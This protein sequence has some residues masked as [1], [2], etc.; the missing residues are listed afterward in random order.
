[1]KN[2]K[3]SNEEDPKDYV[4][5]WEKMSPEE[6]NAQIQNP[7]HVDESIWEKAKKKAA[8]EGHAEK[9]PLIMFLYEKMGGK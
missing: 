6:Q 3:Y 4:R 1:M 5:N 8:E 2:Y 9:W 7:G